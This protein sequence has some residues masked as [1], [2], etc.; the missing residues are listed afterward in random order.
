[1]AI[2]VDLFVHICR[3]A[4]MSGG[5]YWTEMVTGVDDIVSLDNFIIP[6]TQETQENEDVQACAGVEA[7]EVRAGVGVEVIEVQ[8]SAGV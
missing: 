5:G 1:M 7:V 8:A 4:V 6:M 2:D 3:L